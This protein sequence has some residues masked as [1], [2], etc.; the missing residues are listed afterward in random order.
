MRVDARHRPRRVFG[1]RDAQPACAWRKHGGKRPCLSQDVNR[2][3]S[4]SV[5]T[6]QRGDDRGAGDGGGVERGGGDERCGVK[7][8]MRGVKASEGKAIKSGG[9]GGGGR[10]WGEA[11]PCVLPWCRLSRSCC[12]VAF[13]CSAS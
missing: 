9:A 3:A 7:K 12:T 11:Q 5:A 4:F 8:G 6:F 1:R 13:C 10:G 2:R